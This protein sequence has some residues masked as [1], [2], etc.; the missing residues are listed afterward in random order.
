MAEATPD[1]YA[2]ELRREILRSE[3]QRVQVL[4]VV[5]TVLL[6]T[7]LTASTLLT[8]LVQRIFRGGLA[9]WEPLAS[10]GPFALYEF[11]VLFV[12]SRRASRDG[13][14]PRYARFANAFIETSLPSV[15]ILM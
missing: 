12:L 11:I 1:G 2:S 8:D 6:A 3:I 9:W 14:F 5:L 7:T 10:V 4:A 15:M 13:D